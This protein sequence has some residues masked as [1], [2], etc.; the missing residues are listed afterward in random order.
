[1]KNRLEKYHSELFKIALF[2]FDNKQQL[3]H[4]EGC[5][6]SFISH[7]EEYLLGKNINEIFPFLDGINSQ[8]P[9]NLPFVE[10]VND[11][12]VDITFTPDSNGFDLVFINSGMNRDKLQA[13]QQTANESVLREQRLLIEAE[14]LE[15]E[16]RAKSRFI[17]SFSHELYTPLTS[18]IG[19]SERLLHQHTGGVDSFNQLEAV[20]RNSLYLRNMIDNI[21]DQHR[22][23][24][25]Q[26]NINLQ[27]VSLEE[28]INDVLKIVAINQ[29]KPEVI[30]K[31]VWNCRQEPLLLLDKQHV[32]QVLINL[33]SNAFKYTKQGRVTLE[34]SK[35][36]EI[37]SFTITDTG[38]GIPKHELEK[39]QV[40]YLRASNAD[41]YPG[42]GIGLS[43]SRQLVYLMHGEMFLDSTINEGTTVQIKIPYKEQ[44][45]ET[46]SLAGYKVLMIDDDPDVMA[47]LEYYLDQEN[48]TFTGLADSKMALSIL[49]NKLFDLVMVDY[50]LDGDSGV[51]LVETIRKQ[52]YKG[53]IVMVTASTE[54]D[55]KEKALSSG[56][57]DM[58]L[59]PVN[60]QQ[61]M[62]HIKK[63]L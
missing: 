13:I 3:E 60:N 36:T 33:L 1:M 19:Y 32:T 56:C 12:I 21:L 61:I 37:I 30:Y 55:L 8:K 24:I 58:M 11:C 20:H 7:K 57:D 34:I 45:K 6:N 27:L 31:T 23:D 28:I 43:L 17:S 10:I 53:K 62:T 25:N 42:T 15:I 16:N 35:D 5:W 4:L 59:K 41:A 9:Q 44:I 38:I 40:N 46:E 39:V 52:G 48:I 50:Y 14:R 63:D 51:K 26:V 49:E 54:S 2:R 18:I 29:R 47:L 22:M